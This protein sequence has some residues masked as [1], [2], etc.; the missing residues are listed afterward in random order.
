M[1]SDEYR[2][3]LAAKL[4]AL[5]AVLEIAIKKIERSLEQSNDSGDNDE[6]LQKI[7]ENLRNT[8]VTCI[9]AKGMLLKGLREAENKQPAKTAPSGAREY[10]EMLSLDEYRKFQSMSPIDMKDIAEVDL[11][12]LCNKLQAK[13]DD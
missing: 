10:T 13:V 8:M 5:I 12:D 6:R 4:N 2:S 9:R 11:R 1:N 7:H 3:K